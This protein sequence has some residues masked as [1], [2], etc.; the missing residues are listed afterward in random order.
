MKKMTIC[1]LAIL[2]SL[3]MLVGCAGSKPA[4]TPTEKPAETPAESPAE[5]PAETPE[6]P[7]EE[8]FDLNGANVTVYS[9]FK[10]EQTDLVMNQFIEETG[11]NA[12]SIRL[13]GGELLGRISAEKENPLADVWYGGGIDAFIQAKNDGLI[14]PYFSPAAENIPDIYKDPEGYF[15]GMSLSYLVIAYNETLLAENGLEAPTGWQ[16]LLKPEYKGQVSMAN[17]GSSGTAYAFLSTMVQMYGEDGGMEYMKSLNENIKSYEK[18]GGAPSKLCAQGEVMIA[19][20]FLHDVLYYQQEGFDALKCVMPV[21]GTGY[22]IGCLALVK[23]AKNP[24]AAKAFIDFALRED[25]FKI[26]EQVGYYVGYTL[27][28]LEAADPLKA[29][30]EIKTIEYDFEWSGA[31]RNRIVEVWSDMI[32][33]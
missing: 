25:M 15:A 33:E 5:T 7:A 1:L 21:E 13:S 26:Q 16:D 11:A 3:A 27:P 30:G 4:E 14:E 19:V 20:T 29:F 31:N 28:G 23:G 10:E 18:S 9:A 8:T 12:E 22:D 2:L 32:G 24:E 17:P 6:A